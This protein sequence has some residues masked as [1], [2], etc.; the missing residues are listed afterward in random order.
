[1]GTWA[2]AMCALLGQTEQDQLRSRVALDRNTH[3]LHCGA[4]VGERASEPL[5]A[6]GAR[7]EQLHGTQR[8]EA[9]VSQKYPETAGFGKGPNPKETL[10][11]RRNGMYRSRKNTNRPGTQ[12]ARIGQEPSP[13][14][15]ARNPVRPNSWGFG[16]FR[17]SSFRAHLPC[18]ALLHCSP[19]LQSHH[20]PKMKGT[21]WYIASH[22]NQHH[23]GVRE[24][25]T[26]LQ[27]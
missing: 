8:R 19:P 24:A 27:R 23:T 4:S 15:S 5:T 3:V 10:P 20:T 9:S 13:P 26:S 6:R 14:E 11:N 22:A 7:K 2:K 18:T 1:L 17:V 25:S 16:G 12:S 21:L